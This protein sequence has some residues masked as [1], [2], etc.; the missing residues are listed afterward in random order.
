MPVRRVARFGAVRRGTLP[1]RRGGQ[2][3]VIVLIATTLL[4]GLVFYSYNVGA[5]V[6]RRMALQHASD[7]AV[8][9]GSDWMA[10]SMNVVAMNNC[11]QTR[12][13]AL[14]PIMDSL[15]KAT[16]LAYDEIRSWE[17]RLADQINR[18]VLERPDSR[19]LLIVGMMTLQARQA[20][21]RDILA[22]MNAALNQSGFDMRA[23]TYWQPPGGSGPASQGTLWQAVAALDVYNRAT[24]ESA[25][26]FAQAEAVAYGRDNGW[27]SGFLVDVL[28]ALPAV[29]TRFADFQPP[30]RGRERVDNAGATMSPSGGNG[31][32][33]PDMAYPHRLGPWARL[34]KWRHYFSVATQWEWVPPVAGG[35]G[36]T[37][38]S[39]GNVNLTGRRTGNS[40]RGG[41][42]NAG[43]TGHWRGTAW[44]EGGYT[45]YGPYH[46]D[47][48]SIHWDA[49]GNRWNPGELRDTFFH[50]YLRQMSD[51]KLEYMFGSQS[52]QTIHEPNWITDYDAARQFAAAN[53]GAVNRTMFYLVEVASSVPEG[54]PRWLQG[55]TYRTNGSYP[56]TIWA[57]GWVDT[58]D[59]GRWPIAKIGDYVWKDTYSYETTQDTGIGITLMQGAT[60]AVLWQPVYL[61]AWY[62]W[63]GIDIGGDY[64]VPN[65]CNWGSGE[66]LPA[67]WL[68]DTSG[69][70]Y[71]PASL[72]PDRGAR[73]ASFSFLAVARKNAAAP[74]WPR[75]FSGVVSDPLMTAVAQAKLFNHSSWDLWT[76]DWQVQLTPVTKMDDW[77][78]RM[79]LGIDQ[80][81]GTNGLVRGEDVRAAWGYLTKVRPLADA[82]MNH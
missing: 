1:G 9:S 52:P 77:L 34:W 61:V 51:I 4:A 8:I 40:A 27:D 29:R 42:N 74:V 11:H 69:G 54:D 71:D 43:V 33:I 30:I 65:P 59:A 78:A 50:D 38:G 2:V 23:T 62:V 37:R 19:N 35:W 21:Q 82:W 48:T 7:A 47:I 67:P 16:Q 45:T 17:A 56:I 49:L 14:V 20:Q 79:E 80:A 55:G 3:L 72:D 28:P 36:Q 24:V 18:D 25:G 10:R 12:L 53:P 63:G 58:Q 64:Q 76:Q 39:R 5:V 70:D 22:P 57:N 32:A 26:V 6:N 13:L 46:Q 81:S 75:Q 44:E 73:R 41:G 15:P 66:D 60:G 68:L 31:G